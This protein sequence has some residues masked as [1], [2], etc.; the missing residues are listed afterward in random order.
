LQS[1]FGKSFTISYTIVII[2]VD[3]NCLKITLLQIYLGVLQNDEDSG[4]IAWEI[5]LAIAAIAFP[6]KIL[7][8]PINLYKTN[9]AR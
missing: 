5:V 9:H 3:E 2:I 6:L 1:V 8:A 7:V 4:A